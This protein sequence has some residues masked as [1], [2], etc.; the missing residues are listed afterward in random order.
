MTIRDEDSTRVSVRRREPAVKSG[1]GIKVQ[2]T[3]TINR[4]LAEVYS[5]W[6]NLENL[7]GFMKHLNSVRTVEG[8]ISHWVVKLDGITVEWDAETIESRPNELISWRSLPAAEVDNAGSVWFKP[9]MG[10]RGTVVKVALKYAPPGG[11]SA[12]KVAKVFGKDAKSVIEDDM[13]RL[14]SLL[15]TGE[16]PTTEGQP[17]G[18]HSK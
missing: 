6:L 7:T 3:V 13:Y 12:S 9:A 8:N 14:K 4:P 18:N 11:K 2:K 5:F 17:Q 1:Q 16:I 10:N 15:E